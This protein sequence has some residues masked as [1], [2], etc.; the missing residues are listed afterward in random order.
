MI[1]DIEDAAADREQCLGY[2]APETCAHL[3][4]EGRDPVRHFGRGPRAH[5]VGRHRVVQ[6]DLLDADLEVVEHHLADIE[7]AAAR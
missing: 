5:V 3:R 1:H 4:R 2:Q 7:V 6:H